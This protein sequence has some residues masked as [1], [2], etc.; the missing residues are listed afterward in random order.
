MFWVKAFLVLLA[1][2]STDVFWT[3]YVTN[4]AQTNK[5]KAAF[6]STMII[7]VGSF[8]VTEYVNDRIMVIPAAI[9][10]FIGTFLPLWIQE[11]IKEFNT[12]E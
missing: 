2:A 9:G 3:L 4:A 10:A 7:L 6:Y 11:K 5:W 1:T 12:E 8:A